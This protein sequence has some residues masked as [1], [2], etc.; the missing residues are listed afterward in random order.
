MIT[1]Y[2]P[3]THPRGCDCATCC[4]VAASVVGDQVVILRAAVEL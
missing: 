3:A 1:A 2:D 4:R